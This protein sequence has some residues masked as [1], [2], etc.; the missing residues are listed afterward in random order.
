LW[1]VLNPTMRVVHVIPFRTDSGD[2]QQLCRLLDELRPAPEYLGF[3]LP[4]PVLVLS[5]VFEPDLCNYLIALFNQD[6]GRESGFMQEVDGKAVEC[7]DPHWKR[8][9]DLLINEAALIQNLRARISR[10]IVPEIRKAFHFKATRIE[11]DL[12]S[13]YE[14]ETGGHFGAHRDDTV[15]ATMHRRF[16]VSINLNDDFRGGEISFPE[17]S[18]RS[19]KAPVGTAL[20]FAGS[21]LHSVSRVTS[22]RRYAFLPFLFDED[23]E[24]IRQENLQ[25]L[26]R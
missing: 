3:E 18:P 20:V 26:K 15:R 23:A 17:Y 8:R 16:A 12:V 13:C 1:I 7:F 4:P 6:G 24:K 14:A 2:V 11:R 21:I 25:F 19:F 22:G 5:E 9:K 10:R